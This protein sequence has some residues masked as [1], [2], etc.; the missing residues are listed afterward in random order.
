M[1]TQIIFK[2]TYI[3][4]LS[5]FNS[6]L[7]QPVLASPLDVISPSQKKVLKFTP[8]T[9]DGVKGGSFSE[10]ELKGIKNHN[11]IIY[12]KC[13]S[14]GKRSFYSL[15]E[16]NTVA[17]RV[18]NEYSL[19]YPIRDIMSAFVGLGFPVAAAW[20]AVGVVSVSTFGVA[21]LIL[22]G[23]AGITVVALE[24]DKINLQNAIL[25][26]KPISNYTISKGEYYLSLIQNL[27][28]E[29]NAIQ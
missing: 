13:T 4:L 14:F 24:N 5:L 29:L 26:S 1:K 15:N 28:E 22:L 10:C 7:I 17:E 18:A 9:L 12:G 16:L 20:T 21:T 27:K 19:K 23:S 8:A 2:F 11:E 25:T 3:S 6:I